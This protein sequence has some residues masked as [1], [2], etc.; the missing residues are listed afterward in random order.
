MLNQMN[1][2]CT[3]IDELVYKAVNTNQK[4]Q[5]K[6]IFTHVSQF[7]PEHWSETNAVQ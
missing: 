5:I 7:N 1:E 3:R 6:I 4:I 2:K